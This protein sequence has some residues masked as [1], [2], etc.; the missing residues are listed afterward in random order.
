MVVRKQP[1]ENQRFAKILLILPCK[2]QVPQG[3]SCFE[4]LSRHPIAG[5][6]EQYKLL[7]E[8]RESIDALHAQDLA[9]YLDAYLP[10][11]QHILQTRPVI[12]HDSLENKVRNAVLEIL[13]RY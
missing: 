10:A 7:Q 11:F 2:L 5:L 6:E 9:Q 4:A 13:T 8:C 3:H 1:P 12:R